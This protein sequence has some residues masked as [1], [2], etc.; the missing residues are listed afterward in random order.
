MSYRLSDIWDTTERE[1]FSLEILSIT[2]RISILLIN[3]VDN[4]CNVGIWYPN[5]ASLVPEAVNE[6]GQL[7]G[8]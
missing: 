4:I 6:V 1:S 3:L 5:D 8:H 7:A 2:E